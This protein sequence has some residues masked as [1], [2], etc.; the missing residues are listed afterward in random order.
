MISY[1]KISAEKLKKIQHYHLEK[2][3]NMN[4]FFIEDDND[5]KKSP[6]TLA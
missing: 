1:N 4:K 3:I 6:Q 2:L 5:T